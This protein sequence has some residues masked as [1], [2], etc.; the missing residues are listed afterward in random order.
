MVDLGLN[1]EMNGRQRVNAFELPLEDE[2]LWM[3]HDLPLYGGN[4]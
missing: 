4:F 2:L 1:R 3:Y